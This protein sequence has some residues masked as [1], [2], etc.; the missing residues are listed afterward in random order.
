M[1]CLHSPCSF[2]A[3][4]SVLICGNPN[5]HTGSLPDYSTELGNSYIF[6]QNF[7]RNVTNLP[8][9]KTDLQIHK[10]QRDLLQLCQS[11][12]L[13]IVSGRLR[14]DSLGKCTFC[15]PLGNSKVDYIVTD[16]D[17][18]SLSAFIVK[19]LTPLSD[20]SNNYCVYQKYRD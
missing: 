6:G 16:L 9:Y 1:C 13:Y 7:P 17:P 5:T 15:P 8:C 10:N 11:L 3:Q 19:P 14:G 12:N 20:H 2:Q 18:F 4:G